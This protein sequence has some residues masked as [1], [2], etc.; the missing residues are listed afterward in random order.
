MSVRRFCDS[1]GREIIDGGRI[2]AYVG[3]IGGVLT[4]V[5]AEGTS[6]NYDI[7]RVCIYEA[8]SVAFKEGNGKGSGV[9]V[10]TQPPSDSSS[11][12]AV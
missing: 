7:C 3:V 9:Q 6:G 11:S 10:V 4:P 5:T 12:T 1:C 8:I 2:S